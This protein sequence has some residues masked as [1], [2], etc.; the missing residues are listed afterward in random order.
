MEELSR[1]N[2]SLSTALMCLLDVRN[3]MEERG[4]DITRINEQIENLFKAK[5]IIENLEDEI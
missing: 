2:T 3:L 5:N 4:E 1:A